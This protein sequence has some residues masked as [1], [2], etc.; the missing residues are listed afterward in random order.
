MAG[1]EIDAGPDGRGLETLSDDDARHTIRYAFCEINGF[2]DW[3]EPL[4]RTHRGTSIDLIEAE[5]RW[6][7]GE[8]TYCAIQELA[9]DHPELEHRAYMRWAARE[10]ATSDSERTWTEQ[11]VCELFS[12]VL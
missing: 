2:P 8:P 1:V 9:F 6:E 12:K 10:R 11:Q 7:R 4:L 3:F 5:I